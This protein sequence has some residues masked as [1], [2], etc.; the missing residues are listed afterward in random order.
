MKINHN[1]NINRLSK[2]YFAVNL[3]IDSSSQM[4]ATTVYPQDPGKNFITTWVTTISNQFQATKDNYSLQLKRPPKKLSLLYMSPIR[5]D[6]KSCRFTL[7]PA[8]TFATRRL[9]AY[10]STTIYI[11]YSTIRLINASSTR[12]TK[13]K[14]DSNHSLPMNS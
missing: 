11:I 8:R 1:I 14:K 2:S 3:I 7:R 4:C 10:L 13:I 5:N 12:I 6:T 9:P